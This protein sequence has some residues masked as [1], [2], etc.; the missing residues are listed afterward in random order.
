MNTYGTAL[1][2]ATSIYAIDPE[3]GKRLPLEDMVDNLYRTTVRL[4]LSPEARSELYADL[5]DKLAPAT[6]FTKAV[7]IIA[8]SLNEIKKAGI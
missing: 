4:A 2:I 8:A 6:P 5:A 7:E 1:V 3:T